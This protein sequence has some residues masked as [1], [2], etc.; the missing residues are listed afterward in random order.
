M[1]NQCN[2]VKDLLPL[3]HE[4]LTSDESNQMIKAHLDICNECSNYVHSIDDED[5]IE[6][7]EEKI[8]DKIRHSIEIDKRNSVIISVLISVIIVVLISFS[9][10]APEYLSYDEQSMHV[11]KVESSDYIVLLLDNQVSGYE[12]DKIGNDIYSVTTWTT[13]LDRML[14]KEMISSIVLNPE[15]QSVKSLFYS[16]YDSSESIEIY[17]QQKEF[18]G[19]EVLPRLVI[20]MYT[21]LAIC[22]SFILFIIKWLT[23]RWRKLNVLISRLLSFTV[24]Y[25]FVSFFVKGFTFPTYSAIR[26]ISQILIITIIIELIYLKILKM[27]KKKLMNMTNNIRG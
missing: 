2:I 15:K 5:G 22:V 6:D 20:G 1:D 8:I 27:R 16:A 24:I 7:V 4:D 12:I 25:V 23:L 3:F 18:K 10:T 19:V 13:L 26:D 11:A 14:N 17:G 9:L 21:T